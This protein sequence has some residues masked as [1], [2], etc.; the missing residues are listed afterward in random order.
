M[1]IN[2]LARE[3]YER[4]QHAAEIGEQRLVRVDVPGW[5]TRAAQDR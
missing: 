4:A 5:G 1:T 2:A 3:H